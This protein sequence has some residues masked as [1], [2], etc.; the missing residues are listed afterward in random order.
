MKCLSQEF[1]IQITIVMLQFYQSN[2]ITYKYHYSSNSPFFFSKSSFD[3]NKIL[4][5]LFEK[6]LLLYFY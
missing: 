4:R 3:L 2:D 5:F 1:H 6:Y